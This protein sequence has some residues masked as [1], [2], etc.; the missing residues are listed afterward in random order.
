MVDQ[1]NSQLVLL[2][3]YT[4]V[5]HMLNVVCIITS[6]VVGLIYLSCDMKI[7]TWLV[8]YGSSSIICY[9][10]QHYDLKTDNALLE[11]VRTALRLLLILVVLGLSFFLIIWTIYGAT[12]L[13]SEPF[14]NDGQILHIVGAIAVVVK[15]LSI[16]GRVVEN[17]SEE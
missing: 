10:L 8:V 15:A 11:A 4:I 16:A 2:S 1:G 14:E 6:L 12:I 13:F 17:K 5:M 3:I 7:G 9:F